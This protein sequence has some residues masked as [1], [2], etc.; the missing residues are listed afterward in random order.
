MGFEDATN[1]ASSSPDEEKMTFIQKESEARKILEQKREVFAGKQNLIDRLFHCADWDE[2]AQELATRY[3]HSET[4]EDEIATLAM[5]DEQ[6]L[7]DE[8]AQKLASPGFLDSYRAQIK[9]DEE[10]L[11]EIEEW[12]QNEGK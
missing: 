2:K 1:S 3:E 10:L 7:P 9:E 11:A 8:W 5:S 4:E 6:A 12:H